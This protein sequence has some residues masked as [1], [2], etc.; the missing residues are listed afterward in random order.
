MATRLP[1]KRSLIGGGLVLSLLVAGQV[2]L[3]ISSAAAATV[4]NVTTTADIAAN[5]G[6][7]GNSTI[8]TAPSP[9]NLS[10]REAT[11]LANNN[12]GT[13]TIN[14]PAGTYDLANGELQAGTHAGQN[15]TLAGSGAATTIIDAGG[16]SR[17]L[18]FDPNIVGGVAGSV[19]GLTITGGSDS[20]FGGAGIIAG[21]ANA[22][23]PRTPSPS[24]AA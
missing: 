10:L 12:G 16:Q 24:P 18:D 2:A 22:S 3:G 7:C 5:T 15:V 8:L 19:S 9:A 13:S 17:V 1:A 23:A 20:G 6:A 21:S 11:C 4:F 14:I